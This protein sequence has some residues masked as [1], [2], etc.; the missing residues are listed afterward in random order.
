MA[1]MK[2][3]EGVRIP[4]YMDRQLFD[5][6]L[7]CWDENK[8]PDL[9]MNVPDYIECDNGEVYESHGCISI[10]LECVLDQYYEKFIVEDG[11]IGINK[12]A[13]YFEDYAKRI[14]AKNEHT[15]KKD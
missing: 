2:D 13:D 6:D 4:K 7:C 15:N 11:G 1:L 8:L 9:C 12:L 10:S 3:T 5:I 14:R